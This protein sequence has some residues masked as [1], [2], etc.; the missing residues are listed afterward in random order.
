M[1]KR[2][3]ETIE[4]FDAQGIHR[5]GTEVDLVSANWLASKMRSFGALP[6]RESFSFDRLD[7]TEA[8]LVAGRLRVEG[9]PLYDCSYTT[10]GGVVGRLGMLGEDADIALTIVPARDRKEQERVVEARRQNRYRAIVVVTAEELPAQGVAAGN[11]EQFLKPFGPPVLQIPHE[12]WP[13]LSDYAKRGRDVRLIAAAQC[14][15]SEAINIGA[16]IEGTEEGLDPLVVMTPRSGWW[17]C[18]SERG[19]GIAAFLEI[20]KL[21]SDA[22]PRRPVIFTA[23]T[24]HELGHIGLDNFLKDNSALPS[25]AHCWIHLGAN[26]AAVD[27]PVILQ[28]SDDRIEALADE[29]LQQNPVDVG[30]TVP[31]GTRP[32]GEASNVYD[33]EGRYCSIIGGNDL[34]HHPSDRWPDAVDLDKTMRCIRFILAT[35]HRLANG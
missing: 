10:A 15:E 27:A 9:V 26:F 18:A 29:M 1:K 16:K 14:V 7:V 32:L 35:V 24:G 31:P 22:R 19:G 2:I 6:L 30:V 3:A 5:T 4:Q 25:T 33:H 21:F 8:C 11:A 34:F 13:V 12:H 17:Q 28:F 20:V 23:N